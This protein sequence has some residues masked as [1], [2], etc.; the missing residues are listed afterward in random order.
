MKALYFAEHGDTSK[1]TYGE[2]PDPVAKPG[3]VIIRVR[4][5]AVNQLDL[6]VLRGWPGMKLQL[7]HIGG[8]D[9]TGEVFALGEGISGWTIGQR[10]ALT[11]GFLPEGASDEYSARG[12]DSLSPAYQ[13][14]GETVRG[15]FA[16]FVEAPAHTL[17]ALPNS[18]SFAH[19]AAPLLV[20]T[21]AWRMLKHRAA[22]KSGETVL[23]VGSGGGLNSFA[24]WLAKDLG[25]KVIALTSTT[26]KMRR[27]SELGANHVLNYRELPDWSREVRL[28]TGKRGADVIVDNVGQATFPQSLSAAARGGRIVTV[29][30]S[31]GYQVT[32]DNRLMFGKQLSLLGSTMGSAKDAADAIAYAWTKPLGKLIDR[33]L[34]LMDGKQAY[35][36]LDNG[37]KCGKVVLLPE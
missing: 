34:P 4:A 11:P 16:Q 33:E 9:I 6:W 10:V 12:E 15:G 27:A 37:E 25:A 28:L 19:A 21:T 24:I 7:P 20:A 32:F 23:I 36:L 30:N 5:A 26:E 1:L 31:S 29:G 17:I 14:F 3:H 35:D 8:A 18:L 2:L 13:I 22:V